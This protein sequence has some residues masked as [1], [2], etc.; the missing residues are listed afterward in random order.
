[1][2]SRNGFVTNS[3]SSSFIIGKS[4]DFSDKQKEIILKFVKDSFFGTVIAR[5]KEELDN[6][7]IKN[8][9]IDL[10][11]EAEKSTYT[12]KLYKDCL[13]ALEKGLI[14]N[15]GMVDFEC[16]ENDYAILLK[17]LWNRLKKDDE[18]FK[19]IDIDLFY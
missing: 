18:N 7:F 9:G 11:N 5:N 12:Y 10:N 15:S 13:D 8:Y 3:S 16:F 6:Y 14:I 17:N 19:G 1:M 4:E 2:K